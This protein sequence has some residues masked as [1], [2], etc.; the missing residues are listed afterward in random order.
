MNNGIATIDRDI[1][2]I[3]GDTQRSLK[4]L[5]G[6]RLKRAE[7]PYVTEW[8]P[9]ADVAE[10][11]DSITLHVALPGVKK[12][13]VVTEV[14]ENTLLISGTRETG[15]DEKLN[16]IRQGIPAGRFFRAFRIGVQIKPS[17]VRAVL[18]DGILQITLPKYSAARANKILIE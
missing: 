13:A 8:V 18:R 10:S 12:D 3:S 7:S 5:F 17:G 2:K 11:P 15:D 1:E 4:S 9:D 14:K 6:V 16:I